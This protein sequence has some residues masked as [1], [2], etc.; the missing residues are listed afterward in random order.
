MSDASSSVSLRRSRPK[1]IDLFSGPGGL[2]LGFEKAGFDIVIAIELNKNAYETYKINHPNT[3][4]IN[5]NIEAVKINNLIKKYK[6]K[7]E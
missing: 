4:V 2:S 7:N 5:V 3:K 1:I 6:I